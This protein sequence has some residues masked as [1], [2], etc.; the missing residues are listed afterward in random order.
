MKHSKYIHNIKTEYIIPQRIIVEENCENSSL[1]L[2]ET[3]R[4]V[5]L[6]GDKPSLVIK[7]VVT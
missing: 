3:P 2:E 4:Q 5:V 6:F 1:I 7:K